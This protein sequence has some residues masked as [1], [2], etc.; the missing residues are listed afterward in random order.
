MPRYAV[1][2]RRIDTSASELIIRMPAMVAI[3][4]EP[5]P[6]GPNPVF[7]N[8]GT[9]VGVGV[10]VGVGVRVGVGVG[11]GVGVS[12]GLG[13]G[14]G[15][16]VGVRTAQVG[17]VIVSVSVVT[18]PPNAK[19]LPVNSEVLPMVIPEASMIV[20]LNVEF[21]PSVVAAVGVQNI[22]QDDAPPSSVTVEF[23]TEV[24][25]PLILKI[26]VP[27]PLRAIPAVP[28]DAAPDVQYT[29][30]AYIPIYTDR[31]MSRIGGKI[32]RSGCERECT[33]LGRQCG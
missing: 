12:V 33:R 29:P 11:V 17:T 20:P 6:S 27:A 31:T 13:V 8:A 9:G 19:A 26:Y 4:G 1:R 7:G 25:A 24:R 23:A 15:V 3:Q 32:D 14:V 2:F 30:G 22:S 10:N 21:A 16:G 28:M 5:S 18:V